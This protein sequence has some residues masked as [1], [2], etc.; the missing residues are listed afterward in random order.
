M[1]WYDNRISRR[2]CKLSTVRSRVWQSLNKCHFE[3]SDRWVVIAKLCKQNTCSRSSIWKLNWIKVQL[4]IHR[5]MVATTL[6]IQDLLQYGNKST[7]KKVDMD[8][9]LPFVILPLL[10]L[11]AT[12]SR[13]VTI[14]VMVAIGM[15][16]LYVLSRPRQK[17]R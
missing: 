3:Q 7:N 11:I 10:L 12:L 5:K 8:A 16:T 2:I 1:A 13:T 9:V 14:I 15:G 17:N 4:V 6:T